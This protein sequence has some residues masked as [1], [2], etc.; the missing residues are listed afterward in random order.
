[1]STNNRKATKCFG[2]GI[3]RDRLI[4]GREIVVHFFTIAG[5]P[6]AL[7]FALNVLCPH[8]RFF[9][10]LGRK[11]PQ[12][13]QHADFRIALHVGI[14][15]I[16]RFHRR[17]AENLQD[18]VLHHVSEG[19]HAFVVT[20]A[21][22]EGFARFTVVLREALFFRDRDLHMVDVFFVP[23]RLEDA[24]GESQHQQIL[25]RL[26][27]QIVVDAIR[28]AFV[29]AFGHRC[30]HCPRA[31]EVAADRLFDDHA[32]ERA[33]IVDR[34]DHA[35]RLQMLHANRHHLRRNREVK[36]TA[37]RDSKLRIDR[38]ELRI[39]LRVGPRTR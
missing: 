27:A 34:G 8:D 16:G 3:G 4:R 29:K 11:R 39:E 33:R 14:E 6:L 28:L 10:I 20:D 13:A 1:M 24:V 17:Q 7:R 15:R 9:D 30:V 25:H 38:F 2:L 35:G 36:H 21:A 19:S 31:F 22:A 18:V 12:A 32:R 23:E 37:G 26:F 5:H